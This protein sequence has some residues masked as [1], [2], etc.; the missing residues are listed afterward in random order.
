MTM[1]TVSVVCGVLSVDIQFDSNLS[2]DAAFE[3]TCTGDVVVS[4]YLLFFSLTLSPF[5]H[6][7][8]HPHHP[9][10]PQLI[11]FL[12]QD[13]VAEVVLL[14]SFSLTHSLTALTA[15]YCTSFPLKIVVLLSAP[16]LS[17]C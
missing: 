15:L 13:S 14:H 17:V 6:H 1:M 8:H 12:T 5:D 11:I 3:R 7:P 16:T 2:N 4:F 10:L 9:P